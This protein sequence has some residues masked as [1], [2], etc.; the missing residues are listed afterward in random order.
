MDKNKNI[1]LI[2]LIQRRYSQ[3]TLR[4]D[5]NSAQTTGEITCSTSC[6]IGF[7]ILIELYFIRTKPDAI[8]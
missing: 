5:D 4:S 6:G 7:P 8:E 1:S 2:L 3:H